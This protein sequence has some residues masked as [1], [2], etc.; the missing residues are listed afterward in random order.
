MA[1]VRAETGQCLVR[2]QADVARATRQLTEELAGADLD[3]MAFWALEL[4]S[5][6]ARLLTFEAACAQRPLAA[7]DCAALVAHGLQAWSMMAP[8]AAR[9]GRDPWLPTGHE[10]QLHWLWALAELC[11]ME[12]AATWFADWLRGCFRSGLMDS[13][14]GDPQLNDLTWCLVKTR[15]TGAWLAEGDLPETLGRYRPLMGREL[16]DREVAV[17]AVHALGDMALRCRAN[18]VAVDPGFVYET[19]PWGLLPLD[20]LLLSR[21]RERRLGEPLPGLA[22]HPWTASPMAQALGREPAAAAPADALMAQLEALMRRQLGAA[23]Q[24]CPAVPAVPD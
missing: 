19:D 17:R 1:A 11:G 20:V 18:A 23:W 21:Q 6:R 7:A 9:A 12:P 14:P 15:P 22:D 5:A 24:L 10:A 3:R 4:L 16:A 13:L 8:L 2:A